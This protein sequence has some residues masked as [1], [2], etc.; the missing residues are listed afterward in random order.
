MSYEWITEAPEETAPRIGMIGMGKLGLPV[1]LAMES[2]GYEVVGYDTSPRV[3]EY[4][5]NREV[6]YMEEGI[7]PLLAD[8]KI[9]CLG[10]IEEVVR[11]AEIV[12]VPVQTP[13]S[14]QYEGVTRMPDETRDFEYQYLVN[15]VRA[16]ANAARDLESPTTLVVISTVLPGTINSHVRPLMND[17]VQLVYNPAFIAMGTTVQDFL[18]PEFVLLAAEEPAALRQM[19]DF[20]SRIH[21][22]PVWWTTN[23]EN[24]ELVKVAYNT[25]ISM[26]IVFANTL[27]EICHKTGADCDQVTSALSLADQRLL[28][29]AYLKGGMGDGGACHPRDGIAMAHL[30]KRLDLSFDIFSTI[31]R[32]RE[33][34]AEWLADLAIQ[35]SE[36]TGSH[37]CVLGKAYKANT[38]LPTGSPS[39][40]L[41]NQLLE[42]GAAASHHDDPIGNAPEVF[43]IATKHDRYAD[44]IFPQNSVVID[45]WGYIPDQPGVTVVRVGRK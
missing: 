5:A 39:K 27:M 1:A 9:E 31:T 41:Y 34:Q 8:T 22:R 42:K 19:Q 7:E 12:F 6:P 32:A 40:L 28:S 4:L 16:V 11:R 44:V 26:K 15:A 17:W 20:Y 35:W 24:A 45:P 18:E 13:H 25:F 36:L 43:V 23:Y 37:I 38:A 30:A 2:K 10:S 21:E 3:C 33:D 14:P 29:P